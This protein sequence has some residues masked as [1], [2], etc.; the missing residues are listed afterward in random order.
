VRTRFTPARVR[1]INHGSGAL[2]M[3]F[4]AVALASLAF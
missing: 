3:V 4:G 1:L 2:L